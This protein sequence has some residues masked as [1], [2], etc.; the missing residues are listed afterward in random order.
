MSNPWSNNT[1]EHTLISILAAQG[2]HGNI[3]EADISLDPSL[4][5][6]EALHDISALSQQ[7][8]AAELEVLQRNLH[9][10]N[11]E[12]VSVGHVTGVQSAADE[13]AQNISQILDNRD[14]LLERFKT[15][16][17]TGRL[18]I[19]ARF[20][21]HAVATFEKLGAVLAQLTVYIS[22]VEKYKSS[23]LSEGGVER[24]AEQVVELSNSLRG[25]YDNFQAEHKTLL[26]I[27]QGLGKQSQAIL[28]F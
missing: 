11:E 17:E 22:N 13:I 18:V 27:R 28:E 20:Q 5:I 25:L 4:R 7:I 8:H 21:K 2:C 24:S 23:R 3:T 12:L 6:I 9:K 14:A 15:P 19:E 10:D 16:H 1:P 26:D